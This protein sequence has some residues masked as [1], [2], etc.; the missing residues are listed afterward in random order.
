M[1]EKLEVGVSIDFR[2][3]ISDRVEFGHW[4]IDCVVGKR[5]GKSTCLKTLV[6]R[7]TRYG[8]SFL[9]LKK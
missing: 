9:F 6:E 5:E 7:K 4:E 3:D 2:P 8:I 1:H